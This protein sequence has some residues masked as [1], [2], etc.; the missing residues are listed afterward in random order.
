MKTLFTFLLLAVGATAANAQ[1]VQTGLTN[2]T[3]YAL[4]VSGTNLFAGT[5]YTG[6]FLTTN[7]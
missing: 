7:N 1:W 2:T 3:V 5:Y 4:A 6:V